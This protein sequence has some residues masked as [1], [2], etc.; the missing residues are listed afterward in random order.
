MSKYLTRE[1]VIDG[2][3][4]HIESVASEFDDRLAERMARNCRKVRGYFEES[5]YEFDRISNI[6]QLTDDMPASSLRTALYPLVQTL[7]KAIDEVSPVP[8]RWLK[9]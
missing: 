9:W 8:S 1:Q 3:L 5:G 7:I 4:N 6:I 2:A